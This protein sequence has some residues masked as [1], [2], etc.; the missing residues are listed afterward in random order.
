[1]VYNRAMAQSCVINFIYAFFSDIKKDWNCFVV[2]VV[3]AEKLSCQYVKQLAEE[4]CWRK[5]KI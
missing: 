4:R 2:L 1:M 5:E 3:G